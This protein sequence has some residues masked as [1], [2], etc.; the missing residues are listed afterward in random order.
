MARIADA[1]M[2]VVPDVK[3]SGFYE[4]VRQIKIWMKD[5]RSSL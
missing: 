2:K 5:I 1:H 4:N 3:V